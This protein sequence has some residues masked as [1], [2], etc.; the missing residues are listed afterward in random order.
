MKKIILCPKESGNTFNV[1]QYVS[2][3]SDVDFKDITKTMKNDFV[4]YDV[5]ILASGVYGNHVHKN[6]VTWINSIEK[7]RLNANTKIYVFL[8]W[9]GRGNSDKATFNE[10]KRLLSEKDI[11]L[12]E[13]YMKCYGKSFGLIRNSHPNEEDYKN[14]LLWATK[15][16]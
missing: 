1:C 14:V 7:N 8:T 10:I 15:L 5:I 16:S 2:S 11:K 6:I 12:E 3:N 13:S 4:D 9:L